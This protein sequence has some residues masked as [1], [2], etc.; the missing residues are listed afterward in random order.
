MVRDKMHDG[1]LR[2]V[3]RQQRRKIENTYLLQQQ[4]ELT[5]QLKT[6]QNAELELKE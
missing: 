3:E 5:K 1:V 6:M 4:L 2:D